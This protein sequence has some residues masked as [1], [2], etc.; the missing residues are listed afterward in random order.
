MTR[1]PVHAGGSPASQLLAR[2]DPWLHP[3]GPA[4]CSVSRR[5]PEQLG[6]EHVRRYQ[7][8]LLYEKS[9]LQRRELRVRRAFSLALKRRASEKTLGNICRAVTMG[10]GHQPVADG[11]VFWAEPSRA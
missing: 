1:S 3:R 8:Y 11:V 10:A 7:I 4:V 6:A 2:Y 9:W 5:S